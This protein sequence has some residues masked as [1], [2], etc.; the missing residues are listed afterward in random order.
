LFFMDANAQITPKGRDQVFK[1]AAPDRFIKSREKPIRPQST[2]I[3]VEPDTLM[4]LHPEELKKVKFELTRLAIQG[5][6]VYRNKQF[7]HLYKNFIGKRITLHHVYRIADAITKKYRNAGYILTKAIVP[8]QEIRNGVVRLDIME[9]FIENVRVKGRLKG[10]KKLMNA[11]RKR[12][13]KS[14]PLHA[15]DLERYLLLID[16]LPVFFPPFDE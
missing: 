9:G 14:R 7:F 8:P 16:D 4:P 6:T 2:I 11:Y 15:K 13:L 1:Q 5:A 3:Q 10:P 12:L